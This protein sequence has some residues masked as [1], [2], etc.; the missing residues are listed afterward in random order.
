MAFPTAS[1]PMILIGLAANY[2]LRQ[3]KMHIIEQLIEEHRD[4]IQD[5]WKPHFGC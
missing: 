3:D 5:A 4:E 2:G 1:S